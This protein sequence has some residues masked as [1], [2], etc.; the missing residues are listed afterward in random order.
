MLRLSIFLFLIIST[1]FAC[2]FPP[3]RVVICFN[4]ASIQ[5]A[6]GINQYK[7]ELEKD[8]KGGTVT[9]VRNGSVT[10][11]HIKKRPQRYI[12]E[13]VT[14]LDLSAW[15]EKK[16][17]IRSWEAFYECMNKKRNSKDE[18]LYQKLDRNFV[19]K[20][21]CQEGQECDLS[22]L[23]W[24]LHWNT[25]GYM[26]LKTVIGPG[27]F[28]SKEKA[29]KSLA[30]INNL[31]KKVLYGARFPQNA[32][33][34]YDGST[35]YENHKVAQ[36]DFKKTVANLL[37]K[38]QHYKIISGIDQNDIKQLI[39]LSIPGANILYLPRGCKNPYGDISKGEWIDVRSAHVVFGKCPAVEILR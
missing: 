4:K 35:Y 12:T 8:L 28:A 26:Q 17:C 32:D 6:P 18:K 38:M 34:N 21:I 14:T 2:I 33:E 1:L 27:G 31:L 9:I 11:I 5:I 30:K 37:Q 13:I 29:R 36:Y 22:F 25:P 39:S 15:F 10:C 16:E 23:R 24:E 20:I 19:A 3:D 7:K